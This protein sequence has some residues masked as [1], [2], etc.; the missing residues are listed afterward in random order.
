MVAR[1]DAFAERCSMSTA[2]PEELA[3]LGGRPALP[4]GPPAWPPSDPDVL[5]ALQRAYA[6]GSW[7]RYHGTNCRQLSLR[8]AELHQSQFAI[9]CCSGTFAVEL[10]LRGL[11]IGPGDEVLLA[12]YDFPGNFRSIEAVGARPVL[13]DVAPENSNL[14]P[15]LI[16]SAC[17]PATKALIASHLHGGIVPMRAVMEIA[18]E[19]GLTVVEDACQCPGTMVE[20]RI[21]G[22]WGDVGVLSFGGSKLLTAGRGGALVTS[23]ADVHQRVKLF[24]ERG[25]LAFPLSELQAAVVIPQLEKLNARNLHRCQSAEYLHR[26]FEALPSLRPL[27]NRVSDSLP[28]YYKLGLHYIVDEL[29]GHS[30]EEFVAAVQAEG[31]AIGAGFRDFSLRSLRRCR[32]VGQLPNVRRAGSAML[33]L[34]HPVLLSPRETLDGVAAALA[35]VTTALALCRRID[36]ASAR[37][38]DWNTDDSA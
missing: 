7:G 10:A 23:R 14:D 25:N 8:L 35:K 34:H 18:R 31:V 12:G 21:A 24:C 20:G 36:A 9:L 26:H 33:V 17:G 2:R 11:K 22:T 27:V 5:A 28:G 3:I 4:E 30:R 37:H 16:A 32:H 1:R 15:S 13:V 19:R 6:D 29:G 38:A